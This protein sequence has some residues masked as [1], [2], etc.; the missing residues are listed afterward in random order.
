MVSYWFVN[1]IL[2]RIFRYGYH[3]KP[4]QPCCFIFYKNII[5]TKAAYFL[6]IYYCTLFQYCKLSSASVDSTSKVRLSAMLLITECSKLKI[7]CLG[8]PPMAKCSYQIPWK[9]V[10]L[11]KNWKRHTAWRT[12]KPSSFLLLRKESKL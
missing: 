5:L 1:N 7:M 8:C 6:K 11:F 9:S 2:Y 12:Y 3:Q 4:K 10:H